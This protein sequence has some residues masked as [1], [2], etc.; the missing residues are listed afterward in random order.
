M[1]KSLNKA[2]NALFIKKT[3]SSKLV[4]EIKKNQHVVHNLQLYENSLC[5]FFSK[6]VK[7]KR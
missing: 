2:V 3:N 1:F 7:H 6:Y 4:L 5:F